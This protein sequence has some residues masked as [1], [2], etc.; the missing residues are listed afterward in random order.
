MVLFI[1]F[2]NNCTQYACITLT[3]TICVNWEI[4][5]VNDSWLINIAVKAI[6]VFV[7]NGF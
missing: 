3:V 7:D 1:Y 5:N 6:S 4:I 2:T